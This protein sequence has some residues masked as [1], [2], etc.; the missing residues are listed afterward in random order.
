MGISDQVNQNPFAF[1]TLGDSLTATFARGKK[2][3]PRLHTPIESVL[4][5]EQCLSFFLEEEPMF[6]TGSSVLAID[7]HYS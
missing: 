3:R 5:P 4:A 2:S 6:H 7:G 1:A